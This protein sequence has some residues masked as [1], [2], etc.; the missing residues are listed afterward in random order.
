M[1][2][3]KHRKFASRPL[4]AQALLT[5][6][7]RAALRSR[8]GNGVEAQAAQRRVL[9]CPGPESSPLLCRHAVLIWRVRHPQLLQCRHGR[10]RRHAGSCCVPVKA[11][12]AQAVQAVR[13][14]QRHGLIS[15]LVPK[16]KALQVVQGAHPSRDAAPHRQAGQPLQSRQLRIQLLDSKHDAQVAQR[17]KSCQAG[18]RRRVDR[19]QQGEGGETAEGCQAGGE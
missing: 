4:Q 8:R 10:Q 3:E 16:D 18:R 5:H 11:Q 12:A 1:G 17:C 19:R 2:T 14:R 7:V 13:M 6:I 15:L 9:C